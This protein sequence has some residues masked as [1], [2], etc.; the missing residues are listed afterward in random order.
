[1]PEEF[2]NL[3]LLTPIDSFIRLIKSEKQVEL[4]YAAQKLGIPIS[5]LEEWS[6][7]LENEG[8][9]EVKYGIYKIIV[10]WKEPTKEEE[11]KREAEL[12]K[13]QKVTFE[14][15]NILKGRLGE[16]RKAVEDM[17]KK[18]L[19][20]MEG[21]KLE[22]SSIK[23]RLAILDDIE[24]MTTKFKELEEKSE[25]LSA[26]IG[27]IG[28][29]LSV[30]KG[31]LE[32][33]KAALAKSNV[34]E[35]L[36]NIDNIKK[37]ID[38]LNGQLS[39]IEERFK[40]LK[41]ALSNAKAAS[42]NIGEL[43]EIK[44]ELD[45]VR[46]SIASGAKEGLENAIKTK[47]EIT[48]E[49][50]LKIRE[51]NDI[52]E[53]LKKAKSP[54]EVAVLQERKEE[55]LRELEDL[56]FALSSFKDALPTYTGGSSLEEA[57]RVMESLEQKLKAIEGLENIAEDI[58]NVDKVMNDLE[59][60]NESIEG[61]KKALA[62]EVGELLSVVDDEV[63]TYKHY[64]VIKDR[65]ENSIN[66]YYSEIDD[67][68]KEFGELSK[69]AEELKKEFEA[70]KEELLQKINSPDIAEKI[71]KA[72]GLLDIMKRAED[73]YNRLVELK[74]ELDKLEKNINILMKQAE[75]ARLRKTGG[76]AA[77]E[78]STGEGETLSKAKGE[79]D[80]FSSKRE[81]VEKMLVN[82]WK[83]EDGKDKDKKDVDD[84]KVG[85][86]DKIGN[87]EEDKKE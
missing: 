51:V 29:D 12:T 42:S 32:E 63:E 41:A 62:K 19:K 86:E 22:G 26:K 58:R 77:S 54:D 46:E 84:S 81:E 16:E 8:I 5:T 65:V 87:G 71:E 70:K 3:L 73:H 83:E 85:K 15:G 82:L 75:L 67:V 31:D 69:K 2:K 23:E 24:K 35:R 7:I 33:F 30:M 17:E 18:L 27:I 49:I 37:E 45:K 34:G 38:K 79:L 44:E 53:E 6:T 21:I 28:D 78:A 11:K 43:E 56:K 60:L 47:E 76:G 66:K 61:R 9:I 50:D 68:K 52:V 57:K 4:N 48:K 36:R 72:R 80:E 20:A 14:G 59:E 74:K 1:M 25:E 40:K 39:A 64:A 10:K 13:T 55:L